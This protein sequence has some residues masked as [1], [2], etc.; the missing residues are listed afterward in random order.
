MHAKLQRSGLVL[1]LAC[2][3]VGSPAIAEQQLV[4]PTA[5][6]VQR[7]RRLLN[8]SPPL[9]VG[10]SRGGLGAASGSEAGIC[11]LSPWPASAGLGL[12]QSA[13]LVP[14]AAP[15][16]LAAAPLNE[17]QLLRQ[18]RIVWQRRASS[19]AA[20]EGPVPWPLE[21]LQPGEQVL[22]RL[23]PRS[24]AGADFA[25]IRLQ[26]AAAPVLQHYRLLLAEL[27]SH[28]SRWPVQVEAALSGSPAL[29]AALAT[30]PQAPPE[31]L[32]AWAEAVVCVEESP[33]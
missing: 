19:T 21:P 26:A 14:T 20:I 23:R 29:A 11:L 9:A 16:L 6:L 18:G 32:Q 1:L 3:A 28:P 30:D 5:S 10:G 17:I 4:E 13:A 8:L 22:L 2:F 27:K 12:P 25:E 31:L 33:Q 7:L 15:T 24:A